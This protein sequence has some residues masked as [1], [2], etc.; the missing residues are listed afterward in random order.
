M[1]EIDGNWEAREQADT[2]D[3]AEQIPLETENPEQTGEFYC[4]GDEAGS[5]ELDREVGHAALAGYEEIPADS[6]HGGEITDVWDRSN[7]PE[8]TIDVRGDD[9]R[10]IA[11]SGDTEEV[12]DIWDR[13]NEASGSINLRNFGR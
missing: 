12:Y 4:Q 1:S 11:E 5:S 7:E 6:H 10:E 3:S 13:R 8:G 9:G 2:F